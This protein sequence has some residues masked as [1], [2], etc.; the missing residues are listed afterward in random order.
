L[1]QLKGK[2]EGSKAGAY[3]TWGKNSHVARELKVEGKVL[4]LF[5]LIKKWGPT[6]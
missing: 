1:R 2:C 4:L 3:L 6:A 5:W